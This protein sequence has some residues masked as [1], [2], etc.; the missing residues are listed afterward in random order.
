MFVSRLAP[1][2]V[3]CAMIATAL[4]ISAA[5]RLAAAQVPVPT[6]EFAPYI[7]VRTITNALPGSPPPGAYVGRRL[8]FDKTGAF[9]GRVAVATDVYSSGPGRIDL[10]EP[11]SGALTPLGGPDLHLP[12]AVAM[13]F[14]GG[15]FADGVYYFQQFDFPGNPNASRKI[16]ALPPGGSSFGNVLSTTG[17]D[18]GAGLAFAP[19]TFGPTLGGQLFGSDSGN[20][21]GFN[22]GD[23]IRRWDAFGN[24]TNEVMGPIANNPD[25]YTDV[26]FTGPEF[27]AF[28]NRLVA[29]NMTGVSGQNLLM[30]TEAALLGQNELDAYNGREV[31]AVSASLPVYRATYGAYGARGYLFAHNQG[32]VYRYNASGTRSEFLTAAPGFNDVEFGANRTLYV[33]DLYNGL[34]E[35]KPSPK[36]FSDWLEA[37]RCPLISELGDVVDSWQVGGSCPGAAMLCKLVREPACGRQCLTTQQQQTIIAAVAAICA[38]PC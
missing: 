10:I 11:G 18:A 34:Y 30:W 22:S 24:F 25:S 3:R 26:T 32:S 5:P 20:A 28:S 1:S 2:F 14:P 37:T 36:V 27:G 16:Y 35:V 7:G 12:T 4:A 8:A 9:G 13:P 15:I 33:A 19:L 31:F 38:N 23:G 6:A 21:P 17:M 29:V